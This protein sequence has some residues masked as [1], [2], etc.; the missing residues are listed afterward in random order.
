M[1]TERNPDEVADEGE[2]LAMWLDTMAGY[3]GTNRD[4]AERLQRAAAFIR[5]AYPTNAGPIRQWFPLVTEGKHPALDA[6]GV[7]TE[8]VGRL[9]A[10]ERDAVLA[11]LVAMFRGGDADT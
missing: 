7:F 10:K 11:Y 1:S 9:C 4:D 5:E 6:I 8:L 3:D 2:T